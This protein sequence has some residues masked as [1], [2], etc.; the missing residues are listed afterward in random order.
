MSFLWPALLYSL[1]VI[2]LGIALYI[3]LQQRR[4]RFAARHGSFGLLSGT[5]GRGLSLRRQIPPVFFLMGLTL[6]TLALARPQMVV[7]LPKL[8]GTV[9]LAFD[10][11]G[12]MAADDVQPTR[13]EAAKAAAQ[14]FVEHQPPTVQIGVVAFSDNSFAV[15]APTNDQAA[16]LAAIN[17]LA[18]ERGTS[19]GRG[20]LASLNAIAAGTEPEPPS[21]IYSDLLLTPTPTPT[22]VPKGVH[23]AAVI[24]LLTDGEN[25]EPPDPLEAAQTA[26]D[27][28]VR[29]YPVGLGSPTGTTLDINGFTVYTQ[30]DETMLQ[31]IA[32]LTEGTYYAA[33]SEQDL[34]TIYA[35]LGSQLILKPEKTEV[36]SLFAGVGL[37]TFLIGGAFSL[38][39]FNRLP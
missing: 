22:P 2:P 34:R 11:S 39:W 23:T 37:L 3:L 27:R 8:E 18:P 10:V 12:S 29:I 13:M 15:Q 32:Q 26:A 35:D 21:E 9:I 25:N 31:Q 6:L 7:G 20:I 17:R 28:G 24:V 38:W 33:Q 1:L 36:T 19:L 30:L 5:A 4:R 14:D 16:V